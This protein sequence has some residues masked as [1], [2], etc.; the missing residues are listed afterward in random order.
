MAGTPQPADE[1]D[2]GHPFNEAEIPL[3]IETMKNPKYN[4][5]QYQLV[6]KNPP[7]EREPNSLEGED[8]KYHL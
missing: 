6:E 7:I 2:A 1:N 4:F 5:V 3:L 8:K